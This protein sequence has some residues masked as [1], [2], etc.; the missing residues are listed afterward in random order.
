MKAKANAENDRLLELDS[1]REVTWF[2]QIISDRKSTNQTLIQEWNQ[3][4]KRSP[5]PDKIKRRRYKEEK[6]GISLTCAEDG[7]LAVRIPFQV[8]RQW[9]MRCEGL[10]SLE[11][12][13]AMKTERERERSGWGRWRHWGRINGVSSKQGMD[14]SDRGGWGLGEDQRRGPIHGSASRS[15]AP[16]RCWGP[17]HST[18]SWPSVGLRRTPWPVA[19]FSASG[20]PPAVKIIGKVVANWDLQS[21]TRE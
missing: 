17:C 21:Y 19:S 12:A 3:T 4:E 13:L 5:S 6:G 18:P 15:R 2:R 7:S 20:Q 14:G 10:G 16:C 9:R 8:I 1:E 11:L